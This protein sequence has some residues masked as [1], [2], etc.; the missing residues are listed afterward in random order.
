MSKWLT[1]R[2]EK[3]KPVVN[4]KLT[5]EQ[6]ELVIWYLIDVEINC[7]EEQ[8]LIDEIEKEILKAIRFME[9]KD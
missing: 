6:A 5:L 9:D 7:D 2:K 4:I 8:I 3:E 1:E